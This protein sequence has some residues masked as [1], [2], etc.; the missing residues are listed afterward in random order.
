MQLCD[1]YGRGILF[2][3]DRA[4]YSLL[5]YFITSRIVDYIST[6]LDQGKSVMIITDEGRKIADDIYKQLGRTVTIM[7]GRG[8]DIRQQKL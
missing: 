7:N 1:I 6:G 5:T 4:L 3:L 8:S 2:G